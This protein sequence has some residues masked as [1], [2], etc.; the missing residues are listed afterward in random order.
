MIFLYEVNGYFCDVYV[1]A[2]MCFGV[3]AWSYL[4]ILNVHV[5]LVCVCLCVCVCVCVSE[6]GGGPAVLQGAAVL[7]V[8]R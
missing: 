6:C 1:S 3:C 8:G 7:L 5:S 2:C 4:S